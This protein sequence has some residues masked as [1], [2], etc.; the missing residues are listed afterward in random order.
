M[1]RRKSN[2]E[3][4]A[5]QAMREKEEA[6]E[7]W[8]HAQDTIANE[9]KLRND[10]ALEHIATV[11][12]LQHLKHHFNAIRDSL[13]EQSALHDKNQ[14]ERDEARME[15]QRLRQQIERMQAGGSG[16]CGASP[17]DI[18]ITWHLNA[19]PSSFASVSPV[20]L[21]PAKASDSR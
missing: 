15:V 2:W 3:S 20:P 12:K 1:P 21:R 5:S 8:R 14:Q 7:L 9:I 13:R 6:L 17:R 11:A 4:I 18:Q 16:G 19:E 10:L